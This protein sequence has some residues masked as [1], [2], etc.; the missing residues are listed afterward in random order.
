MSETRFSSASRA[1]QAVISGP[2]PAMLA[3]LVAVMSCT[4]SAPSPDAAAPPRA[5]VADGGERVADAAT[6]ASAAAPVDAGTESAAPFDLPKTCGSNERC[7][8]IGI[9][10]VFEPCCVGPAADGVCGISTYGGPCSTRVYGRR[11]PNC[12]DMPMR[13]GNFFGIFPGCC[14][15]DG[16]CGFTNDLGCTAVYLPDGSVPILCVWD[17]DA[18]GSDLDGGP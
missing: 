2:W 14:R 1:G 3:A 5:D 18:G 16:R 17:V 9:V 15:P 13:F 4:R 6:D 8:L 10:G 7:G 12:P 11:D